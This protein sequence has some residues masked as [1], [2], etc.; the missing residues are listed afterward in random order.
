[1]EKVIT[2]NN[3]Q[4]VLASALPVVI[5]F[6]APW[7]G[8]C[9]VLG[10]AIDELAN[11]YIGRAIVCKCNVDDCEEIAGQYAIR[12]IPSVLFFK[13]GQ[14]VDRTAGLVSKAELAAKIDSLV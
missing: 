13:N 3:I 2:E 8:P 14:L 9:R 4:E 6:W 11:E 1:M 5:D 10:P 7:C 12:N